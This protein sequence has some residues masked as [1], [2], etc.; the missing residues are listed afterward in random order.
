[1]R[2]NGIVIND[3]PPQADGRVTSDRSQTLVRIRLLED[4]LQRNAELWGGWDGKSKHTH[5]I[6]HSV[7]PS[8]LVAED[9]TVEVCM[10]F[11]CNELIQ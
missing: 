8:I 5:I 3:R 7:R 4:L 1:M 11:L 9:P 6:P 10:G 2:R